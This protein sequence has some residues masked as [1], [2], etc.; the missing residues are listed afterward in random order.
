MYVR[1]QFFEL[2]KIHGFQSVV[3]E[4]SGSDFFCLSFSGFFLTCTQFLKCMHV[5]FNLNC[6][7]YVHALCALL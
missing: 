7:K 6:E 2:W 5:S 1:V 3:Y 4:S